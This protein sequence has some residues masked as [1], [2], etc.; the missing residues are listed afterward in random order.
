MLLGSALTVPVSILM[1]DSC[2][3]IFSL[4]LGVGS[5]GMSNIVGLIQKPLARIL[6]IMPVAVFVGFVTGFTNGMEKDEEVFFSNI[7]IAV[8]AGIVAVI[9]ILG[10]INLLLRAE[11]KW[12][13]N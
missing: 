7:F 5:L 13:E 1:K 12:G 2:L 10:W 6:G 8:M 3:T 9:Y 4:V 11:K